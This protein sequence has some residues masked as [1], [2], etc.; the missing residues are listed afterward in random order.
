MRGASG[1]RR[2]VRC[3][4]P[5]TWST[6]A[7]CSRRGT[8]CPGWTF[9][10]RSSTAPTDGS[11]ARRWSSPNGP[12]SPGLGKVWSPCSSR[13]ASTD[14]SS[15]GCCTTAP[16]T[17]SPPR[18]PR[19][20]GS[21]RRSSRSTRPRG[22]VRSAASPNPRRRRDLIASRPRRSARPRRIGSPSP[23]RRPAAG[24]CCRAGSGPWSRRPSARARRTAPS[25][26]TSRAGS[27]CCSTADDGS[28]GWSRGPWSGSR[29]GSASATATS[30]W[31]TP[32]TSCS[33]GRGGATTAP[34][35]AP[36]LT[37]GAAVRS[38]SVLIGRE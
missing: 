10:W 34:A 26:A 29:V 3:T 37:C 30:P 31:R 4:S 22:P 14:R 1:R 8:T 28:T 13:D 7:R 38:A 27:R 19:F 17:R 9:R 18:S 35:L 2:S 6:P 21:R 25:C 20:A 15:G 16:R 11:A 32:P 12:C 5:S 36:R 33:L 23:R 24:P